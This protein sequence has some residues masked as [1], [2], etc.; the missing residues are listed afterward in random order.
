[1]SD[2]K[3]ENVFYLKEHY[4]KL[5]EAR[6]GKPNLEAKLYF[7]SLSEEEIKAK[8]RKASVARQQ[9]AIDRG[10]YNTPEGALSYKQKRGTVVYQ[11]DKSFNLINKFLTISDALKFLGM[12]VKKYLMHKKSIE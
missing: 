11:Y 9:K 5:A 10:T 3:R 4:E 12:S 8:T 2:S 1:M 7:E 6:K